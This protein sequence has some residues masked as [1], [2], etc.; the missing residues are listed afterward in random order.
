M[1]LNTRIGTA[2]QTEHLQHVTLY[3]VQ[4]NSRAAAEHRPPT[5]RKGYINAPLLIL[6]PNIAVYTLSRRYI[7]LCGS[8]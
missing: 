2:T 3:T 6:A 8:S 5:G 4:E 7:E 1:I